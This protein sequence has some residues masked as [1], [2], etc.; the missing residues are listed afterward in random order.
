[1]FNP[2]PYLTG[3]LV[4]LASTPFLFAADNGVQVENL[5]SDQPKVVPFQAPVDTDKSQPAQSGGEMAYQIQVLQQDT[6]DLRGMVEDLQHQIKQIQKTQESR[7]LDLDKRIQNLQQELAKLAAANAAAANSGDIADVNKEEP[8]SSGGTGEKAD[9]EKALDMIRKRK[10]D[11]ALTQLQM[12]ISKYPNGDYTANAYYWMGEVYAA[13]PKPDYDKSRQALAQVTTYFPKSRKVPDAMYKL[14][15]VY[16]LMGDCKRAR[17]TLEQVVNN[18]KGKAVANL[19]AAFLRDNV[20][21]K[22]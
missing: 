3:V 16:F 14:G 12:V 9:Y 22:D 7:Y 1:M 6:R 21:C 11:A 17:E 13:L 5:S 8:I 10:Y 15:K 20:H 19:A 4:I 18:Y 2:R